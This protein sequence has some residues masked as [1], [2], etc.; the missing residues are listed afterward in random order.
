[1]RI[2]A[3]IFG[4]LAGLSS[5]P[6]ATYG[7]AFVG[8]GGGSDGSL[9]YL[10]PLLSFLGA[11]IALNFPLASGALLALCALI[12]LSIGAKFGY[13]IN[14][15]TIGPVLLN[16]LGAILAFA[17]GSTAKPD[18][19]VGIAGQQGQAR[20]AQL[21]PSSQQDA[22]FEWKL[23]ASPQQTPQFDR[24]KWNALVKYDDDIGRVAEEVGRLGEKWVD[25]FAADYLALG[26][27]SYL[28]SIIRKILEQAKDDREAAQKTQIAA[29]NARRLQEEES[30]RREEQAQLQRKKLAEVRKQRRRVA[31]GFVWGSPVRKLV[32]CVTA[33][34]LAGSSAYFSA[35]NAGWLAPSFADAFDYCEAVPQTEPDLPNK[36]KQ[37]SY[38]GNDPPV[39]VLTALAATEIPYSVAWRCQ[40]G[41]VY[42]CYGGASGRACAKRDTNINPSADTKSF[43]AESPASDF[44]PMA[45]V[46]TSAFGWACK[47]GYPTITERFKLDSLGYVLGAWQKVDRPTRRAA[48]TSQAKDKK[49]SGANE[50][51]E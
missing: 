31:A 32:T 46:G 15:I 39:A 40:G 43:C 37:G 27:K 23:L 47:N 45:Y 35:Y 51:I 19:T 25:I 1:M 6:L 2:A 29:E 41:N 44:I 33:I 11:G 20:Q 7:H 17:G 8:L 14:I 3:L 26:D 22:S 42:A 48:D 16:G 13:A 24:A 4:I 18:L 30:R 5:L 50:L 34:T 12:L 21:K 9:L 28:P 38:V 49:R 36:H 10:I